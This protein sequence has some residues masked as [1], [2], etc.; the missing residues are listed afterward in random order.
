[1]GSAGV[2][3]HGRASHGFA[4]HLDARREPGLRA[5]SACE[6]VRPCAAAVA[7]TAGGGDWCYCSTSLSGEAAGVVRRSIVPAGVVA[8]TEDAQAGEASGSAADS[9]RDLLD[10]A[11]GVG[12]DAAGIR[13]I[14]DK[15]DGADS[16]VGMGRYSWSGARALRRRCCARCGLRSACWG[17]A[18]AQ[19][20][21]P[22]NGC[23]FIVRVAIA[24]LLFAVGLM[25]P[26]GMPLFTQRKT[27][28][29]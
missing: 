27:V 3:L 11:M 10:R 19:R 28:P 6:A 18:S 12:P 9:G 23:S 15:V 8:D 16:S 22:R 13:A 29:P 4:L 25:L 7:C 21:W 26:E 20:I 2:E 14:A 24:Y 17:G 5:R 1:M